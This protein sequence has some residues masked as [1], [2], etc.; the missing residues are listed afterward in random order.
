[1]AVRLGL[2]QRRPVAGASARERLGRHGAHRLDVV[3]VDDVTG[4]AVGGRTVGEILDQA[5]VARWSEL[6]VEVILADE[7]D[8][9]PPDRGEVDALVERA[10]VRRAVAEGRN[11]DRA[12]PE[13]LRP[14]SAPDRGRQASA[15]DPRRADQADAHVA[16]VHRAA[17]AL[18]H[19]GLAPEQLREEVDER[20]TLGERPAVAAVGGRQVVGVLELGAHARRR[21]LLTDAQVRRAVDEPVVEQPRDRLLA[22]TNRHHA[23]VEPGQFRRP[24]GCGE[25]VVL[26]AVCHIDRSFGTITGCNRPLKRSRAT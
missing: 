2:D 14:V 16:E 9:Q 21:R 7:D 24:L 20:H 23:T 22:A 17:A 1:V 3:A 8:R 11:R 13:H 4:N 6:A 26:G 25:V 19:P 18:A 10:D 15:D 12:R 5:R